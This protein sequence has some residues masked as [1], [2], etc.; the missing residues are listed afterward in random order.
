MAYTTEEARQQVLDSLAA[1]TADLGHSLASLGDAH[2]LLDERLAERLEDDLFRPVQRAYGLARRAYAD[3]AGEAGT[4]P[5][6]APP[7]APS[8]GAKAF[9]E[10]AVEAVSTADETLAELQDSMLPVEVGDAQLR[11]RLASIR[12]LIASVRGNAREL[13]RVLGR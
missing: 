12:E 2:E 5:E 7:G 6:Q 13:L 9:V 8:H 10:A 4:E 3:F 1:A 11:T